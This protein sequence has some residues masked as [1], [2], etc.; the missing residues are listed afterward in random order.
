MFEL[1]DFELELVS[2]PLLRPPPEEK[3]RCGGHAGHQGAKSRNHGH[4][5]RKP[6]VLALAWLWGLHLESLSGHLPPCFCFPL[7]RFPPCRL[8]VSPLRLSLLRLLA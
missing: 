2:L 7:H 5:V 3:V 6:A 4:H 1:A 8:G